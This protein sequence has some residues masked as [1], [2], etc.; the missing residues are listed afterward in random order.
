VFQFRIL[1]PL[2]VV[3]AVGPIA[4]GGPKQRATLAIL[5]LNANRVV[6][7]ERLADDLY[8][9]APPV[10]AVT[11]V[12]RQVSGLRK[13]LGADAIETRPPGYVIRVP[14]HRIDLTRFEQLAE[15]G[16]EALARGD[17]ERA[18]TLL[19]DAL[20]LWRGAPLA[21]LEYESFA[22][23]TVGRLEE[24]RLAALELRIDADLALARHATLVPELEVLVAEHPVRE[25]F[26]AQLMLALYRAGRQAEALEVYHA[27]RAALL[28]GL[29][30]DPSP[31]LQQLQRAILTHDPSLE[32]RQGARGAPRE[33]VRAVLVIPSADGELTR[34]LRLAGPLAEP[35]GREVIVVRLL[36]D[37]RL[38]AGTAATLNDH[39]AALDIPLRTAAFTTADP[40]SDAVRLATAYEVDLVIV[41][42]P[43]DVDAAAVPR[44]LAAVVARS[45]ADVA[46]S[47]GP[48]VAWGQRAP[49]D[50]AFSGSE[51]DWAALELAARLAAATTTP[52]RLVGTK[53]D[54]ARGRRDASRLLADASL[55]VQRVTA[56]AVEP[57]LAAPGE[58]GLLTATNESAVVVTGFS[59]RWR[60]EGVGP[61]RR[62]LLRRSSVPVLLVHR[63]PRPGVLAPRASRTRFSWS[64]KA[65]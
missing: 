35:P 57:L 41:D 20:A 59:P 64:M 53:A 12:Q 5:L 8:A 31:E 39:R 9:G 43:A 6:S 33:P 52:L 50:V 47:A 4:L 14:H 42:A 15:E 56:V 22:Q 51:H 25:R 61:S 21:D 58:A 11:Q 18:S 28:E 54:P 10:T 32:V 29:G 23:A 55:A 3:G 17:A 26:R 40:A 34:L 62:A 27:A 38:L 7:I 36:E 45:P 46:V 13:L 1:G 63:G 60:E 16:A 37:D 48:T 24:I 2:E 19:R 44:G 30:I 49:I 65:D